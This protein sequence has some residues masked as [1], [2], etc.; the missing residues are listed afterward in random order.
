MLLQQPIRIYFQIIKNNL[1]KLFVST[2][3]RIVILI[4][5]DYL[6]SKVNDVQLLIFVVFLILT[7][8]R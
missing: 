2:L 8:T 1:Q 5:S 4:Y 7:A 3:T 6:I